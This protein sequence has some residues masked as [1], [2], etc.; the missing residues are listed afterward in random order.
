VGHP[1]PLDVTTL[2]GY[3][4]DPAVFLRGDHTFGAGPAG[5]TGPAGPAGVDGASG[6]PGDPGPPGP[7]GPEGPAGPGLAPLDPNRLLGRSDRGI[8]PAEP[9]LIGAGLALDGTTLVA[10]A[11]NS[12]VFGYGF[13]TQTT[14]PPANQ[15]VR[16]NAGHPYTAATKVWA[17]FQNSNSEDLYFGWMRTP[18]G[19]TLLVQDKDNHVQY[20]E[21]TVT[22]AVLDKGTYCEVPVVWRANGSALAT[23][24]VLVRTTTPAVPS[25]HHATHEPGGSDALVGAAWTAQANT[26]TQDQRIE[27]GTPILNFFDTEA[28]ADARLFRIYTSA[29]QFVVDAAFDS[30]ATAHSNPLTLTRG[31]DARVWGDLYEKNRTTPIGHWVQVPFHPNN[32]GANWTIT[33]D[34]VLSNEYTIIGRTV[35]WNLYIA[36]FTGTSTIGAGQTSLMITNPLGGASSASM[37]PFAR[38]VNAGVSI[39]VFGEPGG[40]LTLYPKDGA[41]FTAGTLGLVGQVIFR[42]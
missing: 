8:G 25:G 33:A 17:S 7:P 6:P 11:K 27:R 20:A 41:P 9:L 30:G 35:I 22:G 10:T 42:M 39:D 29:Q 18:P 40:N 31:G 21:F 23:Q 13:S 38:C 4:G 24:A 26:F 37:S 34:A 5:P 15:T 19:S 2:A 32:F 1:D 36:W 3:P 12:G 14:E 28:P 16:V